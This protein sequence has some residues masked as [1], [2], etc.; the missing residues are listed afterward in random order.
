MARDQAL[1][2]CPPGAWT[3]LTNGDITAITFQVQSGSVKIRF[4]T[5]T[6]PTA[7]SDPGFVYHARPADPQ[8]EAGELR[9]LV[10]DLAGGAGLD[11]AWAAPINGRPAKVFVDHA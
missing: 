10:A 4:T 6:A 8:G 9:V 3:E 7:L 11:R 2:T 1:V 5:G